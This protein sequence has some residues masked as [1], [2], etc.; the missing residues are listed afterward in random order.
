MRIGFDASNIGGGG[1]ITHLKEIL[2]NFCNEKIFEDVDEIVV[3][4]SRKTLEHLRPCTRISKVTFPALNESLAKRLFFQLFNYDKEVSKRCDILLSL[5]GD[6]LGKFKPLVGMSR[7]MLLYERNVW[8]DIKSFR[9][10]ARFYINYLKQKWCFK[11][12]SGIIFISN[13][14][15]QII[16]KQLRLDKK[17]TKLIHHGVS[18]RFES[19]VKEQKDIINYNAKNPFKVLYVSQVHTYKH[20]WN[21]VKAVDRLI[22]SG[23]P[24]ELNLVGSII[25]NPAGVMLKNALNHAQNKSFIIYHGHLPYNKIDNIYKDTDAIIFA[26]TCENMP[27]TLLESMA[28]GSPIACSDK[29]PMPEFIQQD[30]YYFDAQSTDSIENALSR[31]IN[32]PTERRIFAENNLK[33]IGNYS[34]QKTAKETIEYLIYIHKNYCK[35]NIN[36]A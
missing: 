33:K 34:W 1:G 14:A 31:L 6:Y 30:C 21:V 7:N 15:T 12:S 27:N 5:T 20:Q 25:Y 18:T 10:K 23:Y 32:H 35:E 2:E 22:S 3:F 28:S 13:Y 24:I 19:N 4:A 29:Q 8:G 9:E 17:N 36:H 26:S 16:I 11:N